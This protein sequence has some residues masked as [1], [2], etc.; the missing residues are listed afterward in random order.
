MTD[1]YMRVGDGVLIPADET[2]TQELRSLKLKKG[3]VIKVD[4]AQIRSK[5]F[6]N[7]VHQIGVMIAKEI[8]SFNGLDA[9]TVIKRIQ[10][11][12]CIECDIVGID[13]GNF[14]MYEQRVPR[15]ISFS[16][17]SESR[18]R[19]AALRICEHISS[20]YWMTKTPEEVERMA[21]IFISV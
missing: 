1:V 8:E 19:E 17:M 20:K 10:I 14:G 7:L 12:G 13:M 2:Q 6:N 16:K 15:S 18:Y 11:E 9:H 21:G 5:K 4:V 3:D